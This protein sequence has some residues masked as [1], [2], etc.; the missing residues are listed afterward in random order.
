MSQ[1]RKSPRRKRRPGQSGQH[2]QRGGG[3]GQGGRGSS[4]HRAARE[5]TCAPLAELCELAPFSVFCALHLWITETD[6]F[7]EQSA[8]S[9][10]HRFEL[11]AEELDAYLEQHDLTCEALRRAEFDVDGAR[12]DMQV[13]PEGISRIELARTLF[14]ELR[15]DDSAR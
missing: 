11:S 4:T 7:R 6:G 13:A 15:G 8:E 12:L 9:V 3:G 1:P 5:G 10:A 14:S 2:R